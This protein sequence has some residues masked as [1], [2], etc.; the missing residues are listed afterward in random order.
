MRVACMIGPKP[1]SAIADHDV[2]DERDDG[3]LRERSPSS[4][5]TDDR[6]RAVLV[7]VAAPAADRARCRWRPTKNVS[8]KKRMKTIQS[9]GLLS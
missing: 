4:P 1:V 3:E 5:S 2:G 8:R 7:D 9:T 6:E